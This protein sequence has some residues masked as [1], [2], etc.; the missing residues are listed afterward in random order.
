MYESEAQALPRNIN[1]AEQKPVAVNSYVRRFKNIQQNSSGPNQQGSDITIPID[2]GT[3]GAFLDVSMSYL[4]LDVNI[5][6]NCPYIDYCDFGPAG[7]ASILKNVQVRN[8]GLGIETVYEYNTV[9]ELM[10]RLEG[11][12]QTP[13][14]LY[15]SRTNKTENYVAGSNHLN[16]C[17][18]P[19]V[20]LSGRIMGA[21]VSLE[22]RPFYAGA[23]VTNNLYSTHNT[24]IGSNGKTGPWACGNAEGVTL[25]ATGSWAEVT[26]NSIRN[27]T[28]KNG[29]LIYGM[30][31][32]NN[33]NYWPNLI[34]IEPS[35]ENMTSRS[36][37]RYQDYMSFLSNVKCIPIG[38]KSKLKMPET[39]APVTAAGD[40]PANPG[41][42][43][44]WDTPFGNA[45]NPLESFGPDKTYIPGQFNYTCTIPLYLGTLGMLNPKMVPTMLLDNFQLILTLAKNGEVFKCTMDPCRIIRGTHRDFLTYYGNALTPIN[46]VPDAAKYGIC[47]SLIPEVL[48]QA[49]Q[50][51]GAKAGSGGVDNATA[52]QMATVWTNICQMPLTGTIVDGTEIDAQLIPAFLK[53][54]LP[55]WKTGYFPPGGLVPQY[56]QSSSTY[57]GMPPCGVYGNLGNVIGN[58]AN[59]CYGT[60][61]SASVPQT[62]RC[63]RNTR[64]P[65]YVAEYTDT[66]QGVEE[67][68]PS[69]TVTNVYY[70]AQQVIIPDQVTAEILQAA[71]HGDISIQTHTIQVYRNIGLVAGSSSQNIVIP[72]K[73]GSAN[74]FFCL[75]KSK[76]QTEYGKNQ[77]LVNSLCGVC[78]IGSANF[79]SDSVSFVGTNNAPKIRYVPASLGSNE[80]NFSFQLVIGN[81]LIPAQPITSA[82]ELLTELEKCQ[83]GLNTRYNNMSYGN[84]VFPNP[85][86]VDKANELV[87]DIFRPDGYLTT[88]VPIDF[89][90]D[91]TIVNNV[92]TPLMTNARSSATVTPWVPVKVGQY[93][94]PGYVV[95]DSSFV[96][97]VDLDTWSAFSDVAMSG[98]YM[99]NNTVSLRC[100]GLSLLGNSVEMGE[101]FTATAILPCDMRWS[102][103]AGGSSV[104]YV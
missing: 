26:N 70:V 24:G 15:R 28:V 62:A 5:T 47:N 4:Q 94:V 78:P 52:L 103:Q 33:I 22:A 67:K 30:V 61:L 54:G 38:C 91:Q 83:H 77:F 81:D 7:L 82:V 2:T 69:Y 36:A 63:V 18:A 43:G 59:G 60:I 50:P 35:D 76:T 29:M 99:G 104:T 58:D 42:A 21:D 31:D 74:S 8:N 20:D 87:Y 75:F 11:L 101:S 93:K 100:D 17:K 40:V 79:K 73:V 84:V 41:S 64:A 12:T 66:F 3:P 55:I 56:Y 80:N 46:T 39:K 96:F 1:L 92:M 10:S 90:D 89:M 53:D 88:Y 45:V 16:T 102:F 49:R 37:L 57:N 9:C 27:Y 19:M 34:G 98:R 97:G 48:N 95:P 23:Y 86:A 72:A 44:G 32:S 71:M 85:T 14:S 65:G 51:Y 6:N 13:F 25:T 68:L